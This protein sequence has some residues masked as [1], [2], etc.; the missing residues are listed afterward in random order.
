[1]I[2]TKTTDVF[3]LIVICFEKKRTDEFLKNKYSHT[4]I[5]SIILFKYYYIKFV[6]FFGFSSPPS[7]N[8]FC[9]FMVSVFFSYYS[10]TRLNRNSKGHPFYF[11]LE[12]FRL[13]KKHG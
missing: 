2:K 10:I 6:K 4:I 13:K 9:E 12:I 5:R 11:G 8:T 7:A 1:M 3:V